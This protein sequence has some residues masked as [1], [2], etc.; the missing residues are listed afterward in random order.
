VFQVF[1]FF[2]D[3]FC[4]TNPDDLPPHD[5]ELARVYCTF[6][7]NVTPYSL[8]V[9][10]GRF[11]VTYCF[12]LQ[13]RRVWQASSKHGSGCRLLL[14]GFLLGLLFDP[15]DGD[16]MF[17]RSD[18]GLLL[19]CMASHPRRYS[20][21]WG[22]GIQQN[23]KRLKSGCGPKREEIK[24]PEETSFKIWPI[25]GFS[26]QWRATYLSITRK[27]LHNL[28]NYYTLTDDL[29]LSWK[30]LWSD[31]PRPAMLQCVLWYKYTNVSGKRTASI[32]KV[33]K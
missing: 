16:N 24:K 31:D 10:Y 4:F 2:R 33:E 29:R 21:L 26:W 17:L 7:W 23:P 13:G 19:G 15:E 18:C 14:A 28:P 3:T 12:H 22:S 8:I 6:F 27:Y 5:S 11:G 1:L 25:L 30:R 9:A 32:F 20:P